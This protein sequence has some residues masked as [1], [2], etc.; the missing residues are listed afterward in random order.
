MRI[1]ASCLLWFLV[2][3]SFSQEPG[4][5]NFTTQDGLPSDEVY[6]S[7]IDNEGYLWFSTNDGVCRFD[8]SQFTNFNQEDGITE[9]T[10]LELVLDKQGRIWFGGISGRLSY[11]DHGVIKQFIGND[12]ITKNKTSIEIISTG[13][14]YPKDTNE[15]TLNLTSGKTL[16]IKGNKCTVFNVKNGDSLAISK[17]TDL[18]QFY[19][20]ILPNKD[21]ARF[22]VNFGTSNYTVVIPAK[23]GFYNLHNHYLY[24]EY[25]D[26]IIYFQGEGVLTIYKN[27]EY[28]YTKLDF[29]PVYA[30]K[31][32]YGG[33]WI[34]TYKNGLLFFDDFDFT[35]KAKVNILK[36]QYVTSLRYDQNTRGWV[37]TLDGGIFYVQ[38]INITNYTC[39][40]NASNNNIS[41]IIQ[42]D[43]STFAFFSRN[44]KV[45]ITNDFSKPLKEID[46]PE[47][48][49]YYIYQALKYNDK[50]FLGTGESIIE[51]PLRFFS[52]KNY[53]HDEIKKYPNRGMKDFVIQDSILWVAKYNGLYCEPNFLSSGKLIHNTK[54]KVVDARLNRVIYSPSLENDSIYSYLLLQETDKLWRIRYQK[55]NPFHAEKSFMPENLSINDMLVSEKNKAIYLATKGQGLKIIIDDSILNYNSKTGLLSNNIKVIKFQNDSTLLLGTNRGLNILTLSHNKYPKILD[56]KYITQNDGLTGKEIHDIVI[57]KDQILISTNKGISLVRPSVIVEMKDKFPINITG[58]YINGEKSN[59]QN[60]PL[61]ILKYNENNV[62]ITYDAIDFHDKKNIKYYYKLD[63]SANADWTEVAESSVTFPYLP[64]GEYSFSVKAMNSYG[65]L[66]QNICKVN[67]IIK[68]VFYK[69]TWFRSLITTIILFLIV[70]VIYIFFKRKTERLVTKSTLAEYHQQSLARA[71][72]PHFIFNALNSV[73]SLIIADRKKD[74]TFYITQIASF[75]REIFNHAANNKIKILQESEMLSNYLKIEQRRIPYHFNFMIKIHDD[76]ASFNIPSFMTQVF[77]ENAI[78]HGFGDKKLKGALIHISFY[79]KDEYIICKITDNGIGR[80]AARENIT[81]KQNS[82]DLHGI[83]VINERIRLLNLKYSDQRISLNIEDKLNLTKDASVGTIVKLK[84]P[85]VTNTK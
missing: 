76:L 73:N 70:S 55:S 79:K 65:Y 78:W 20:Y 43:S 16:H 63:G 84:F 69:T 25:S 33:I 18:Y 57:Y 83:D 9:N 12:Q 42:I 3:F 36:D 22:T 2:M 80:K 29:I 56:S 49:N 60:V 31:G 32:I 41:K 34:G 81:K 23:Q 15:V 38:S 24:L 48:N 6:R 59:H 19:S 13:S 64:S 51:I 27:G 54:N 30:I 52:K 68:E 62:Q 58:F 85:I 74:A 10:I 67:F 28:S 14:L 82:G 72:N 21:T 17:E 66:S 71:L 53:N 46:L 1:F 75:I 35:K 39:G 47:I 5:K 7:L 4:M 11:Y 61:H 26:K 77:V 40:N 8:G 44:N 50:I 45:Y 37:T